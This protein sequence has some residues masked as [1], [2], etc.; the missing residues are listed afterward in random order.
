VRFIKNAPQDVTNLVIAL[1]AGVLCGLVLFVPAT[2]YFQVREIRRSLAQRKDYV[3]LP[4]SVLAADW[5]S[6]QTV[7]HRGLSW[8][9]LSPNDDI[10]DAFRANL[11]DS[12][13]NLIGRFRRSSDDEPANFDWSRAR[14]CLL[15]TL[16]IDSLNTRARGQLHLCDGYLSLEDAHRSTASYTIEAFRRAAALMPR[17]P[18]PHLGL[19][20]AYIYRVRNVGMA[21]A[22]FHQAAQLGYTLGPR[23]REQ[24]A[25]GYLTRA[26]AELNLASLAAKRC[27]DD[28]DQKSPSLRAGVAGRLLRR[29]APLDAKQDAARWLRL[30]RGDMERAQNLYEPITGF[31][32]VEV[33]LEQVYRDQDD[34]AK[35]EQALFTPIPKPHLILLKARFVKRPVSFRW[36]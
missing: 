27:L 16:E 26:E 13:D 31:S 3:L 4:G 6:Y 14:L 25:D 2:R 12:A 28:T 9:R 29:G 33:S 8:P 23:E 17:S 34:Q 35:L 18:D 1:L 22:E 32:H 20:R 30:A 19:A 7:K 24:E 36:R 15:Y 11:L 5:Q 21:L 10:E